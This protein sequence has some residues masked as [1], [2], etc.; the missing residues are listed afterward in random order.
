MSFDGYSYPDSFPQCYIGFPWGSAA[1]NQ[2][3]DY[4]GSYGAGPQWYIWVGNFFDLAL[5]YD[6]SVKDALDMASWIMWECDGF[7]DSPLTGSGFTA[8][9]PMDKE[10]P[11]VNSRIT[12]DL[13]AH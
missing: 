1:L 12:L 7:L 2:H 11:W 3:I 6:I 4:D 5:N 9:W 8:V 13:I 10:P